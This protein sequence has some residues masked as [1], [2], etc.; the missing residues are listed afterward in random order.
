VNGRTVLQTLGQIRDGGVL[1]GEARLALVVEPSELL[2]DLG[3]LGIFVKD[4]FV[5][6]LGQDVLCVLNK[7]RVS[8]QRVE[9]RKE[10]GRIAYLLLRLVNVTD[11][12]P[13]VDLGQRTRW[14]L[15]NVAEALR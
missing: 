3:V 2:K 9:K 1:I 13:D 8:G 12:K 10:Q 5:G 6:F 14:I 15:E 11:L 7:S 4:A